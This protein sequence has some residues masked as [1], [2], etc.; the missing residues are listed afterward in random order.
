MRKLLLFYIIFHKKR[1]F[2]QRLSILR[3]NITFRKLRHKF[4]FILYSIL[5]LF[6]LYFIL[7]ISQ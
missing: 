4:Y 1:E 6:I 7:F 3:E 2:R 5:Y